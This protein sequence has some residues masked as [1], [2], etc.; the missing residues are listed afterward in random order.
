MTALKQKPALW[1]T[2]GTAAALIAGGGTAYWLTQHNSKP[3]ELPVGAAIV[4]QEALMAMTLSTD[5]NQWAQLRQYGTP[6]SQKSLTQGLAE[7]RDRLLTA[8]GYDYDQDIKPW[9]G[10]EITAAFMGIPNAPPPPGSTAPT[11]Q[12]QATLLVL[13]IQDPLRAKQILEKPR[14]EAAGKL[15]TRAYKGVDIKETAPGAKQAFS[16]AALDGKLLVVATDPKAM[17]KAIDT[18]KGA[19]NLAS[20]P[21]YSQAL[22]KVETPNAFGKL[23]V[24]L[25]AAAALTLGQRATPQAQAQAQQVQGL[26]ATVS[27]EANGVQF[28]TISWLKPDSQRKYTVQNNAKTMTSRLP[29]GTLLMASGGNLKQFW[30]DYSQG[31]AASPI[32]PVNPE[33]LR[34]GLRSTVNLDFDKDLMAWMDGEFSLALVAAPDGG[35][36]TLPFG[37]LFMVQAS[38]RRAAEDTLKKLDQTMAD[39]YKFKVETAKVGNQPVT[40]W[41]LAAGGPAITHGWLDNN[42]AFINLGAP[43]ASTIIPRPAKALADSEPFRTTVPTTL[44]PNNGTFFVN[45]DAVSA[46]RLPLLQLPPG[47]RDF[48]AAIKSIGV[49]AAISDDRTTRYDAFVALQTGSQLIPLPAPKLPT[50]SPAPPSPSPSPSPTISP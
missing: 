38:D 2:L 37:V 44:T 4:P 47:N 18:Y 6:Q 33:G 43:V 28:R 45:M 17:D 5:A 10:K 26:A 49:T 13:P 15:V 34:N 35:P 8:N 40:N 1:L 29:D 42:I 21:G 25:P 19:P 9:V 7:V 31:A 23:F 12:Q 16:A 39:K 46:K 27:L 50:E 36:P 30:Q 14:P 22:G 32:S 3:G 48:F 41:T 20:T 11:V 24:N